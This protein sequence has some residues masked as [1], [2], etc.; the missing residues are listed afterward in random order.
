MAL[1]AALILLWMFTWSD[2]K[3]G[4]PHSKK[5]TEIFPNPYSDTGKTEIKR[6]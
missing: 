1:T 2:E 5:L 6:A 3:W 4:M